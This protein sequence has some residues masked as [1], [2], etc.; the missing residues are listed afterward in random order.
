M[1]WLLALFAALAFNAS[2]QTVIKVMNAFTP[3]AATYVRSLGWTL[4]NYIAALIAQANQ[5]YAD[6]GVAVTIQSVGIVENACCGPSTDLYPIGNLAG[7]QPGAVSWAKGDIPLMKLRDDSGADVLFLATKYSDGTNNA[8]VGGASGGLCDNTTF[9]VSPMNAVVG[10]D[11][12]WMGNGTG[13]IDVYGHEIA[14]QLCMVHADAY[15]TRTGTDQSNCLIS[16]TQE[17]TSYTV[18]ITITPTQQLPCW[19]VGNVGCYPNGHAGI[20]G[21]VN[22]WIAGGQT[23]S[24]SNGSLVAPTVWAEDVTCSNPTFGARQGSSWSHTYQ[25]ASFTCP[26]TLA[27]PMFSNPAKRYNGVVQ[28]DSAHNSAAKM[29]AQ[30]AA[31]SQFHK[32]SVSKILKAA[33]LAGSIP[34]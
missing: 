2:A 9:P 6:S 28:G 27:V 22:T 29:N 19:N 20:V 23:C 10:G 24:Y 32:T 33:I 12:E 16:W 3:D 31:V 1:K 14:H 34:Q 17:T 26:N 13:R 8:D 4:P 25:P 30:A 18:G 15:V 21:W 7:I 5:Q 11:V